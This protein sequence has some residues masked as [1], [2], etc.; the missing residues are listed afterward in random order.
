MK[1]IV[2]FVISVVVVTIVGFVKPFRISGDCME[3][4]I[5][6]GHLYFVDRFS[7]HL[8]KYQKEDIVTFEHEGKM[9][10]SRILALGGDTIQIT[11]GSIT[12]NGVA[13]EDSVRRNWNGWNYGMF[14]IDTTFQVPKDRAFVLS[15]NLSSQHDDSRVFGPI[16]MNLVS[17]LVW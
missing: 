5:K 2:I 8:R 1:K 13:L 15:D 17:G 16:S 9:W 12:V 7:P 3:P 4:A 6:D 10:I 14:A 11:E